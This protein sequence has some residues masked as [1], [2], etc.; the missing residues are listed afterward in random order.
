M[1]ESNDG[2]LL[3]EPV[4]N[5][6]KKEKYNKC[7]KKVFFRYKGK[8]GDLLT[9]AGSEYLAMFLFACCQSAGEMHV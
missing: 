9:C 4:I 6:G 1:L 2:R 3:S 8:I 7:F 5:E